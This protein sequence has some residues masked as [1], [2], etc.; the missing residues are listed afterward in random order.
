MVPLRRRVRRRLSKWV[1]GNVN[2]KVRL[3]CE[4]CELALFSEKAGSSDFLSPSLTT[5]SMVW[6]S[7]RQNDGC[8]EYYF[9]LQR[10]QA[11]ISPRTH[12]T[13]VFCPEGLDGIM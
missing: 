5:S 4:G 12:S 10:I 9:R 1:H 6:A 13:N 3:A 2:L 11:Q 8:V 7:W